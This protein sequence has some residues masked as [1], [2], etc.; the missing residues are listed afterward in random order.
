M[1]KVVVTGAN[2][3][4]GKHLIDE[5]LND[6]YFVYAVVRSNFDYK[7]K[8]LKVVKASMEEYDSLPEKIKDNCYAFFHIA[9]DGTRGKTR[10]E[11]DRQKNNYINSI[12]A[13]ASAQKLKCK[14]FVGAGSQAEYGV[15]NKVISEEDTPTPNTAY[16]KYKLKFTNYLLAQ[17]NKSFKTIIPRFFSLFGEG[18]N[19]QTVIESTLDKMLVNEDCDFTP[20]VQ[21]WNFMY[22]K[23][24]VKAMIYLMENNGSGIYNFATLDTRRLKQFILEL[25]KITKS[26]SKL[27][28][29]ALPYPNNNVVSIRPN[30]S[31]LINAGFNQ[32]TPF[33]EAIENI[34]NYKRI[35]TNEKN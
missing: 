5:L 9:W 12:K 30:I 33:N 23:D 15:L 25:K 21:Y 16:G 34:I 29:G 10:L 31:K 20:A 7:N 11:E 14:V 27:N 1:K 17:Q 32:F 26:K 8:N 28:F 2:C 18:D 13:V 24:C 6:G 22:I 19:P 3:F 4:V 35:L